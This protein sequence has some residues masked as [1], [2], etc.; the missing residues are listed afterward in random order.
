MRN[1]AKCKGG[2]SKDEKDTIHIIC[3][4][5]VVSLFRGHN[6]ISPAERRNRKG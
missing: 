6:G 2:R 1:S 5:C 3:V 4:A